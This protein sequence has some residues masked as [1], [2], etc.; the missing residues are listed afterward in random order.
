MGKDPR[1]VA[2]RNCVLVMPKFNPGDLPPSGYLE[3]HEWADVQRKA[4]IKQSCCTR[5]CKLKTPQEVCCDAPR[6]SL[7]ED[8]AESRLIARQVATDRLR[9]ARA[10]LAKL[11]TR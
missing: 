11:R 4:G 6:H 1:G 9:S 8:E 5:C 3:W 7:R 10:A 2:R